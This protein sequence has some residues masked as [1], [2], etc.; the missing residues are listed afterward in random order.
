[1]EW[2]ENGNI[3]QRI[4][5]LRKEQNLTLAEVAAAAN[6]SSSHLSQIERSKTS[7]S[8]MTVASIAEALSVNIRELFTDVSDPYYF[9]HRADRPGVRQTQSQSIDATL[10]TASTG[11]WQIQVTKLTIQPDVAPMRLPAFTGEVLGF[12]IEGRLGIELGEEAYELNAG[13]SIHFDV[14]E[15]QCIRCM[16]DSKCT[17]LW[18]SSPPI[19]GVFAASNGENQ[20]TAES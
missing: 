16:G 7:P 18:C 17:I 10:L 3:G 13:D 20:A 2:S 5:E 9:V 4:K 19:H 8:L 12:V 14:A 15:D 1:M 11:A 6:L